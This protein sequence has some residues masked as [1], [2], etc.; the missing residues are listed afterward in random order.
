MSPP[1]TLF[2]RRSKA[3]PTPLSAALF[4]ATARR[5]GTQPSFSSM[6]KAWRIFARLSIMPVPTGVR[7]PRGKL[8]AITLTESPLHMPRGMFAPPSQVPRQSSI[9]SPP[10]PA[11]PSEA[12]HARTSPITTELGCPFAGKMNYFTG[13]E[14]NAAYPL[15]AEFLRL[16][17]E[18]DPSC[19]FC[20]DYLRARL[21]LAVTG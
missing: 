14:I 20:N 3:G 8:P 6:D 10:P 1:T 2:S 7:V 12:Q 9:I 4:L 13:A 19:M 21:S 11:L 17:I 18:L 5:L 15:L 16:R